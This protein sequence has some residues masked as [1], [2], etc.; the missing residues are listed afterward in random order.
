M[1]I[2]AFSASAMTSSLLRAKHNS[3]IITGTLDTLNSDSKYHGFSVKSMYDFQQDV[4]R[5]HY[6]EQGLGAVLSL[7]A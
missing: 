5:A 1:P 7:S 3:D 6:T 4:L 2:E